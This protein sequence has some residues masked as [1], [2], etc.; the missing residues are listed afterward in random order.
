MTA[1]SVLTMLPLSLSALR[2]AKPYY[3]RVRA[4]SGVGEPEV[5]QTPKR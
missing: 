4:R 2:P 1:V 5:P 3:R